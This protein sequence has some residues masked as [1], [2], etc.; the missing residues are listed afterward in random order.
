MLIQMTQVQ[1]CESHG[2]CPQTAKSLRCIPAQVEGGGKKRQL[3]RREA[4]K[5]APPCEA[6]L[7]SKIL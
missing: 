5:T 1:G 6:F 7:T 4:N 3:F 2:R